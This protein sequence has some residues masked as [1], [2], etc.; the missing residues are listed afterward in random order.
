MADTYSICRLCWLVVV[1]SSILQTDQVLFCMDFFRHLAAE[2]RSA[3]QKKAGVQQ[4]KLDFSLKEGQTLNLTIAGGGT[5]AS[6]RRNRPPRPAASE[7]GGMHYDFAIVFIFVK[8][9]SDCN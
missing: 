7:D 6:T 8:Y 5:G 4:P 3:E 9:E 2:E 1:V